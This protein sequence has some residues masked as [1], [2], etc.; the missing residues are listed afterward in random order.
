MSLFA[1]SEG[2]GKLKRRQT[3]TANDNTVKVMTL[4]KINLKIFGG[5]GPPNW[6]VLININL[7]NSLT[8]F[9]SSII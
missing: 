6:S 4:K 1:S 7:W 5:I 9:V 8:C 2:L 3:V